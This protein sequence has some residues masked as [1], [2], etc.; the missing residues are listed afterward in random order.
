MALILLGWLGGAA[1]AQQQAP[2]LLVHAATCLASKK[3]L[4]T[5]PGTAFSLGSWMDAKSYPG[6]RVLYV[7][8]TSGANHFAGRVFSIFYSERRHREILDIQ[9]G[10]T[11]VQLDH[12]KGPISFVVPPIGGED[13]EGSF[14]SAIQQLDGQPRYTV[15]GAEISGPMSHTICKSYIDND[16]P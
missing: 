16:Q 6:K 8:A 4:P 5:S 14:I 2:V 10:T 1:Y 12:G 13:S 11:F 3:Q 7:V 15:T 9:N